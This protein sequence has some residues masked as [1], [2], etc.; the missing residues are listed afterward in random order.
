MVEKKKS[1]WPT[2]LDKYDGY[3]RRI[4]QRLPMT[5]AEIVGNYRRSDKKVD[6]VKRLMEL[7]GCGRDIIERIIVMELGADALPKKRKKQKTEDSE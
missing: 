6:D 5:L 4:I 3:D 2:A 1:I 7:N